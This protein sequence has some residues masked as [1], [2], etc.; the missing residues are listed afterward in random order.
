MFS[1]IQQDIMNH[2]AFNDTCDDHGIVLW[3]VL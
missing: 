1:I 2:E 3:I